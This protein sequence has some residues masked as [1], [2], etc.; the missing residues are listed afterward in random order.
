MIRAANVRSRKPAMPAPQPATTASCSIALKKEP[1]QTDRELLGKK[2]GRLLVV[3][4]RKRG[5]SLLLRKL[6]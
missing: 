4:G 6:G 2:T 5:G 3:A 1:N